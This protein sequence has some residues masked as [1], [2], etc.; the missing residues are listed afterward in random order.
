M[1]FLLFC[2]S[3]IADRVSV[4]FNDVNAYQR[5]FA[6]ISVLRVRR[7]NRHSQSASFASVTFG[8]AVGARLLH[9]EVMQTSVILEMRFFTAGA[10]HHS[11][12]VICARAVFRQ[13]NSLSISPNVVI[14]SNV[15]VKFFAAVL[16]VIY[17]VVSVFAVVDFIARKRFKP[18][19]SFVTVRKVL[20]LR[21]AAVR[22]IE[23]HFTPIVTAVT[24]VLSL[25]IVLDKVMSAE[26]TERLVACNGAFR[27]RVKVESNTFTVILRIAVLFFKFSLFV[28]NYVVYYT[29]GYKFHSSCDLLFRRHN[30]YVIPAS[31]VRRKHKNGF[32]VKFVNYI[33]IYVFYLT[34]YYFDNDFVFFTVFVGFQTTIVLCPFV[35]HA[36]FVARYRCRFYASVGVSGN[37]CF[38]IVAFYCADVEF[39]L[40]GNFFYFFLDFV[41]VDVGGYLIGN[42]KT[43]AEIYYRTVNIE[44]CRL[45]GNFTARDV[46]VSVGI[47]FYIRSF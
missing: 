5:F 9:A 43:S 46:A 1:S 17:V 19:G 14:V 4:I 12:F 31:A 44:H 28:F 10:S 2:Y 8:I 16:A 38:G 36:F 21:L 47:N 45:R 39:K 30:V 6:Y 24:A 33:F 29:Q 27:H 37:L 23:V 13:V 20:R 22:A 32:F 40:F 7:I 42:Y 11:E 35:N 3:V 26:R 15:P 25:V 41:I 18:D 34:V